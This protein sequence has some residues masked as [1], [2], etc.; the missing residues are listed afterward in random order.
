MSNA[1]KKIEDS[2]L[3]VGESMAVDIAIQA[4]LT[5]AT[6]KMQPHQSIEYLCCRL[7]APSI[8][9]LSAK[10]MSKEAK[11]SRSKPI[12]TPTLEKTEPPI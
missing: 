6:G 12:R 10:S 11:P 7:T 4:V 9:A 8:I 2:A 3:K 5:V 1:N